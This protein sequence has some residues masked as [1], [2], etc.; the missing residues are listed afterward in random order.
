MT[1]EHSHYRAK[2]TCEKKATCV[3]VYVSQLHSQ[4]RINISATV[5][6]DVLHCT[7]IIQYDAQC[8]MSEMFHKQKLTISPSFAKGCRPTLRRH[9]LVN[10]FVN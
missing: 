9:Y 1:L 7:I 10:S 6:V 4:H 2:D 8:G 5:S 3:C